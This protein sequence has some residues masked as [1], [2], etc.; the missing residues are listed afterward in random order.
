MRP[1]GLYD[2]VDPVGWDIHPRYA[3]DDLVH[4]R[5]DDPALEG[6]CLDDD[7]GVLR[8]VPGVEIARRIRRLC[9]DE[10]DLWG[11]ID[12]VAGK[13]LQIRVD[14]PNRDSALTHQRGKPRS[15]RTG[16]GEIH[17]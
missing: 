2:E 7:G 4:L 10:T 3:L 8:V 5:D 16:K 11:K 14:G 1:W 12:K 13:E 9:G 6:R 15:L 17:A